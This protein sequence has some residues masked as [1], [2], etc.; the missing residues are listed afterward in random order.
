ME[1]ARTKKEPKQRIPTFE[2]TVRLL[3]LPSN[4]HVLL[5][6]DVKPS[7]S[8]TR[9]FGLM[10]DIL[11]TYPEWE[12][13]LAPRIILGLWHPS[14]LAPAQSILPLC[15]RMHIGVSIDTARRYFWDSCVGFSIAFMG[16]VGWEG[17]RFRKDCREQGKK[18]M[19]WT[20]NKPE[21][22]MEAVRWGVDAILTDVTK[23]WLDMRVA[24]QSDYDKTHSKYGRFFLWTT[25]IYYSP[26]VWAIGMLVRRRLESAVGPFDSTGTMNTGVGAGV[27]TG[28][29]A[30]AVEA[31]A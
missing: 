7:N 18:V 8:P 17:E 13:T 12:T 20:V 5:N 26:C 4:S 22:M 28:A 15:P 2:E 24:L 6:V 27:P 23:T 25:P 1:H 19:V 16:M 14:F 31:Q 10:H 29:A 11:S 9:L 21:Q 30:V 3:M